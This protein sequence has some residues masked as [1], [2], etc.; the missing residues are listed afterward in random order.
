MPM[1]FWSGLACWRNAGS[2]EISQ[3]EKG[4]ILEGPDR[5]VF[6]S[7]QPKAIAGRLALTPG[8]QVQ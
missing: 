5:I 7:S 8:C 6:P 4:D 2:I 3:N 1:P